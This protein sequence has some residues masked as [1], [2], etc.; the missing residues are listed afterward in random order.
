M[1]YALKQREERI[2]QMAAVDEFNSIL[3]VLIVIITV[4]LLTRKFKIP[5][6]V[7]L[8]IAGL[9]SVIVPWFN[10]PNLSPDLFLL[11]LLPPILFEAALTMDID[12][13][14]K[15]YDVIL[16]F[17][18][19]GTLITLLTVAAFAYFFLG[20]TVLESLLLGIII[21]PTDPVAVVSIFRR[22]G[23]DDSLRLIVEGESLFNDSV[24]LIAFYVLLLTLSTKISSPA[25][26]IV[27]SSL[28]IL[29]GVALGGIGGLVTHYLIN[30]T[31][32][33]FA[34]ILLSFILSFGI[35]VVAQ[36]LGFSGVLA[37]IVAGSTVNYRLHHIGGLAAPTSTYLGIFWEFFSFIA[38]SVAFIFI[39]LNIEPGL[40]VFYALPAALITIF[41]FIER[42]LKIRGLF[43]LLDRIRRNNMP[44]NFQMGLWWAGLRGAVSI[45]MMLSISSLPIPHLEEVKAL[46]VGVVL[47][48]NV[49]LGL[50]MPFAIK[51]FNLT[52]PS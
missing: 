30:F 15:N 47:A 48:S 10:L 14:L 5:Y 4:A 7:A 25:S 19:I 28:M 49:V 26:L 42:Y 41:I 23:V 46:T 45:V 38:T 18:V 40:L 35:Y 51:R 17:A 1:P 6:T 20:L 3:T 29:G 8:I 21:S 34:E 9:I 39:G 33:P 50:T 16:T 13:L 36:D 31:D 43:Y 27:S 37:V 11:V 22:S 12:K 2:T 24:A 32:D 52:H 44:P